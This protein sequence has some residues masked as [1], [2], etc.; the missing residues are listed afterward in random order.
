MIHI[1]VSD[2][3]YNKLKG[4]APNQLVFEFI[5][6]FQ[7]SLAITFLK[8]KS[9]VAHNRVLLHCRKCMELFSTPSTRK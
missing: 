2:D 9:Y 7:S 5:L 6:L 8:N 1:L 4:K 3:K